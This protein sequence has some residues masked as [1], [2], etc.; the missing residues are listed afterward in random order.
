MQKKVLNSQ[1]L[2]EFLCYIGFAALMFYLVYSGKYL[3]Y[4]TPKMA[5]YL[6]F[7]ASVMLIWSCAVLSRLFQPQHKTRAAHCLVLIIPTMLLL[8][9]HKPISASELSSGYLSGDALAGLSSKSSYDFSNSMTD[10]QTSEDSS[11]LDISQD[12]AP[13][14]SWY[15]DNKISDGSDNF[16]PD[17]ETEQY[18]PKEPDFKVKNKKIIVEDDAFYPWLAEIYTT[19]GKYEGYQIVIKGFVFKD[20]ET[21]Q[22]NEFCPARLIMSCCVA[23][24]TPFGII[25]KYDKVAD[26]EDGTWITVEGVIHMGE[27]MGREEP[28]VTVTKISPA[29]KPAQEYVYP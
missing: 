24:L 20:P 28:Q 13:A 16:V 8:L 18:I 10:V 9:P 25:C 27:Y 19:M 22:D 5:P 2:L 29:E 4:V 1:V 7:T 15:A 11:D 21:M 26:L 12:E 6:Y 14:D 23:D 17:T 3:S